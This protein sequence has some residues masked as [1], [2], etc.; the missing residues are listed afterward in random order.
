MKYIQTV[1]EDIS[2]S[3]LGWCQCHEH[4]FLAD[5]PSRQVSKALFMDDYDKSLAEINM[6]KKAGGVSFVDAQPTACGRMIRNL[7]SASKDSGVNI[8]SCTG[9][10]KTIFF[11]DQDL[12]ASQ[13]GD[14][15]ADIFIK[16][17]TQGI[18]ESG[19]LIAKAGVIKCAA[20]VG[21]QNADP[22]YAKLFH[23][24]AA[25]AKQTGAPVMIHMDSGTDAL[26]IIRLFDDYG[27]APNR[28]MF[29]H[30]DRAR[31]DF[32]YHEE[33][34][35]VGVNLEYDTIHRLKYH[36]D[37]KELH[38][39]AHMTERGYAD[40]LML[41]LDTT[42]ERLKSYGASFGLDFLLTDF[43]FSLEQRLGNEVVDQFMVANPAA[44]L[45]F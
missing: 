34:A 19:T 20:V 13:T 30:L 36:E 26:P 4:I 28:L 6:Y 21:E 42:N 43:R 25:A 38:L 14:T 24:A 1:R 12:L 39:I 35:T 5:G 31:Y 15:L 8:I 23:A 17:V 41:S 44:F 11:E 22:T 40:K 3:K 10:H 27:V 9:F 7:V 18:E 37:E 32:A 2:P 45:A 33:L 16:E 29:C